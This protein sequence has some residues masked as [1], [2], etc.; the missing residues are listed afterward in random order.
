MLAAICIPTVDRL[1][2]L[3]EALE[4]AAT[5]S[6]DDY[7]TLV[8]VNSTD[9]GYHD[10]V[11]E[12]VEAARRR[13]PARTIRIVKPS[14]FLPIADH[15]NFM[16]TQTTSVYVCFLGDDDRMEPAFL[17]T[18]VSLL[19]RCEGA[20]FAFCD[21][22]VID[23]GGRVRG[24]LRARFDRITHRENLEEGFI[25]HRA[26]SRLALWNAIWLPC[27]LLRRTVLEDFPFALGHEGPDRDFWLR[28]ADAPVGFGAVYTR[29][30]LLNYR[31]HELQYSKGART[32]QSDWIRT[33]ERCRSV[34]EA[35]P[36]LHNQ[37]LAY[38]YAKLG[39]ALLA[40][41][42][43][44]GAWRALLVALRKNAFDRRTYRFVMQATLPA[45][46]LGYL[47]RLRERREK[48]TA[49]GNEGEP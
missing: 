48:S 25:P 19:E 12:A 42:D 15:A 32:S 39:K 46:T 35:E 30:P 43:R 22:Q 8:S 44:A 29:A 16:V 36:R 47:R 21:F 31:L 3:R 7:E 26:L 18:L 23:G 9:P 38:T 13:H 2:F 11:G 5:Q 41:G 34:A 1:E 27:S 33:L 10:G 20:G 49:S 6:F 24:D 4:S 14:R 17:R 45:S 40:E 28:I 37:E